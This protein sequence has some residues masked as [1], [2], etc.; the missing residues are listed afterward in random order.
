M[1]RALLFAFCI[2]FLFACQ[3]FSEPAIDE[4]HFR[5]KVFSITFE[6]REDTLVVDFQDST[7]TTMGNYISFGNDW[8]VTKIANAHFLLLGEHT[9]LTKLK[10]DGTYHCSLVGR[11]KT[12]SVMALRKPRWTREDL[13]GIWVPKS[14]SNI[15]D[16]YESAFYRDTV[17]TLPPPPPPPPP[18]RMKEDG[19]YPNYVNIPYFEISQDTIRLHEGFSISKSVLLTNAT[20]EYLFVRIRRSWQYGRLENEWRILNL[21]DNEMVLERSIV[22]ESEDMIIDTLVRKTL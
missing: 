18:S 12:E 11:N 20:Y 21:N 16:R 1:K 9:L 17:E 8:S 2:S 7:F 14:R 13:N 22:D 3:S 19:T 15:F 10:N 5:N 4:S 6:G